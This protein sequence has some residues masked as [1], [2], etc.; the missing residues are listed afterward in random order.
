MK[1]KLTLG[2]R[3][4]FIVAFLCVAM[5][6]AASRVRSAPESRRA[7]DFAARANALYKS[8]LTGDLKTAR[9]SLHDLAALYEASGPVS[10]GMAHGLT[11]NYGRLYVLE[12]R[13]HRSDVAETFLIKSRY[14]SLRLA[15]LDGDS[16]EE[17]AANVAT[18]DGPKC[19]QIWS[20]WD[21]DHNSGNEASYVKELEKK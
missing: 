8:Y 17:A 5:S 2:L 10:Q 6:G 19:I 7:D 15:E 13:A 1:T 20:R 11:A 9:Q 21:R 12:Y 14:W 3:P 18:Y 16:E 4:V